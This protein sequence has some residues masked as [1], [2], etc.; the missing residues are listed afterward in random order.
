MQRKQ[1]NWNTG[2]AHLNSCLLSKIMNKEINADGSTLSAIEMNSF[3][4]HRS[5]E[6]D[7]TVAE[8][9][10]SRKGKFS[11]GICAGI[12]IAVA[13]ATSKSHR[14]LIFSTMPVP[15]VC[16]LS[17]ILIG[18]CTCV[19]TGFT[20]TTGH[21]GPRQ[22]DCHRF[23]ILN[24]TIV[25]QIDHKVSVKLTCSFIP[26]PAL[27]ATWS[28]KMRSKDLVKSADSHD[29][30]QSK[31]I[32][33]KILRQGSLKSFKLIHPS[34]KLVYNPTPWTYQTKDLWR[35]ASYVVSNENIKIY[36][37]FDQSFWTRKREARCCKTPAGLSQ[38]RPRCANPLRKENK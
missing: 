12:A 24:V 22:C 23:T 33:G 8:K 31:I 36:L 9:L 4:H 26:S 25:Q 13:S 20:G 35:W 11:S 18:V 28:Y 32:N 15:H 2:K 38:V 17:V 5:T 3:R 1:Y 10:Q 19:E 34:L 29:L 21:P 6:K 7:R 37:H 27:V 16:M 14:P 30:F